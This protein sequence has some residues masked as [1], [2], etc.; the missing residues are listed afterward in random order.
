M[1][2][3]TRLLLLQLLIEQQ[4]MKI[5]PQIFFLSPEEDTEI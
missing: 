5:I 2:C 1:A 3:H 4:R